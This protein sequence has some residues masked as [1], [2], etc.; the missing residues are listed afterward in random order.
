M[1]IPSHGTIVAYLA[2]FVAVGG[3]SYAAVKLP[4]NSVGTVQLKKGAVTG[5]K[6]R[7][8]TRTA[9]KFKRGTLTRG[10]QGER[11]PTGPTGATGP[12]GTVDTTNFYDKPAS[13]AR[14]LGIGATAAN[15]T[16][17][18]G[19][20]ST[21]FA[22][23]NVHLA[24]FGTFVTAGG[25][26]SVLLYDR[27][28]ASFASVLVT[29]SDPATSGTVAVVMPASRSG[30]F[31]MVRSGSSGSVGQTRSVAASGTGASMTF[32]TADRIGV[33]VGSALDSSVAD[34]FLTAP[35]GGANLCG[36]SGTRLG[37]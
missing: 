2:L 24:P 26:I 32:G 17:L 22:R 21:A 10:P 16:M 19:Q 27:S 9:A 31:T 7:N 20:S 8:G 23:G 1:H 34:L 14:F 33:V 13:D 12:T 25:S 36:V 6:V 3:T 15:A 28:G 11:G 29:C 30:G 37:S 35:A 4:R 18:A 5:P